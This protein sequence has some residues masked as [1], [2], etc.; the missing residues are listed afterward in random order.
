[1]DQRYFL[2]LR[3]AFAE[4]LAFPGVHQWWELSKDMFDDGFGIQ[5]DGILLDAEGREYK[6]SFGVGDA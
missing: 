1:M 2:S 3:S 4:L 6:G 5:I